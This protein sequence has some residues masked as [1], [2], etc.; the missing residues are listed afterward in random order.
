[1]ELQYDAEWVASERGRPLSLSLPFGLDDTPLRGDRVF[2][3]FDNLLPDSE[4]IR[5]R[6]ASRFS[7]SSLEPFE[8]LKAVGRDCIGA[9]QLLDEDER[10]E[11]IDRIDATP[12]DDAQIEELLRNSTGPAG[13]GLQPNDDFRI[14]LPGAQE[15]T[16]LL[17]HRG[18]WLKPHGATPT[19][20]ILK[21]STLR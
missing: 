18:R 8:L 6:I 19:T 12:I 15:K 21:L 16:A 7:T 3:Y 1:M 5:R 4:A 2:N 14:S 13:L 9:L 17:R 10:P 20:H 11:R